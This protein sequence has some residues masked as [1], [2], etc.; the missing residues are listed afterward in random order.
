MGMKQRL[1]VAQAIMEEL[2]ILVLDEPMNGLDDVGVLLIRELLLELRNQG[3]LILIASHYKE[4]IEFL[5]DEIYY[6]KDG[7]FVQ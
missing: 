2:D 7:K 3:K 4:D 5:C 1:G 6:C